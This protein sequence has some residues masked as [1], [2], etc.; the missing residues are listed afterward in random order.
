MGT[1]FTEWGT[2]IPIKEAQFPEMST[3]F[4]Q[5]GSLD[6]CKTFLNARVFQWSTNFSERGT[7][8]SSKNTG[9]IFLKTGYSIRETGYSIRENVY[10]IWETRYPFLQ[11]NVSLTKTRYPIWEAGFLFWKLGRQKFW[12][13]FWGT[14]TGSR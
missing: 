7:R 14:I 3:L 9:T 8:F 10:S 2:R 12:S 13:L 4:S 5:M 6:F 1:R 11:Q